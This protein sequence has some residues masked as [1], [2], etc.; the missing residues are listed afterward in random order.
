M[1]LEA[2]VR[3]FGGKRKLVERVKTEAEEMGVGQLAW[4]PTS[5]AAVA[6]AR[7]GQSNGFSKPLQA[8]LDALPVEVLASAAAHAAILERIGC[9]TLGQVRALPRGGLSR[10]FDKELLGALDQAYGLKPEAHAWVQLPDTFAAKLE[11]MSRIE[12]APALLFGARRLLLQLCAWLAARRSGTTAFTL[13]WCHD[14]MRAKAAGDGGELSVRTAEPTRNIEHLSRLLAEN[15]AKVELLAPVGDLA[16]VADDVRPLEENSFSLL[17]ETL[18]DGEGLALVLERI[19]ARLGPERVLR[20]VILE[21]HRPE[22]MCHWQPAPDKRPRQVAR[23]L[24]CPQPTFILPKPLRLASRESQPL[25]QGPLK[26]LI[27]PHRIEHGW[28][29]RVGESLTD[30]AS[31][32]KAATSDQVE[33]RHVARDYFVALSEHAGLLWVYQ[34]RLASEESAWFLHGVFA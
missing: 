27:G 7:T 23:L 22:W 1:E 14:A 9:Q 6:V 4:A 3:L 5:L 29:D 18:P 11:L 15:L 2:S 8:L 21:D 28:F 13:K 10:R 20:P 25:Y 30:Q 31:P 19:A 34:T 24:D 16:L 12:M 33:T 26:F 17:P 32:G